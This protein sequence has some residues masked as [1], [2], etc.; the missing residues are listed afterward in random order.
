MIWVLAFL[1]ASPDALMF[2][3]PPK[4]FRPWVIWWWFGSAAS[5]SDLRFELGEMDRAGIGGAQVFPCYPLG[6]DDPERGIRNVS[7]YSTNYISRFRAAVEEAG[8]R[9]MTLFSA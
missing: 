3:D 2:R 5:E 7:L 4:S 8:R 9:R 1:L 6:A